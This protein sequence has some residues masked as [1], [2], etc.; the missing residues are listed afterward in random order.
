MNIVGIIP[1]RFNSTRLPGKPL[2]DI[3]GVSMVMRVVNQARKAELSE[4]IVATDD[5]R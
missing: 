5:D 4:V 1:A 3:N 2:E